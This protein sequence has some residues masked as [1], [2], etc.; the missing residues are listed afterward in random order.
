MA[1]ESALPL[2]GSDG[3]V[4]SDSVFSKEAREVPAF[5]GRVNRQRCSTIDLQPR[6]PEDREKIEA[7][8][9]AQAELPV[10]VTLTFAKP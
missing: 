4:M 3:V 7:L 8:V 9:E 1:D 2:R 10:G 6:R 5:I